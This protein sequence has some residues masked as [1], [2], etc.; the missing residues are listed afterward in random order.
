MKFLEI[1]IEWVSIIRDL[2][3]N[4]WAIIMAALIGFMGIYV[5]TRSIYTPEYTS[6]ATIVVNAKSSNTGSYSLFSV[7]VEM[8]DV[9]SRVLVE[10]TVKEKAS[11]ILKI[12]E[13]DGELTAS[14]YSET[15]FINLSVSSD[16]PQKSYELLTAVLKAYPQVS[17]SVFDNVVI[18]ILS[19]PE[20]P[21]SP[22][23]SVS[24]GNRVLVAGACAVLVAGLVVVFSVLRD[25]VKDEDDFNNKIDAKLLGTI[26]HERKHFSL[27]ERI[28]KKKKALLIHNNA[29]ISL[30]FVENYHKV[31]AKLEHINRHSGTKVFAITSVAENE[32]KSTIASNVAISLADRGHK[33]VLIDIDC[34]KPALY[35]I[36]NKKFNE[37][38]EFGY[39]MNGKIKSNEFRLK[40]YK[41]TSL[42]LA[43]NTS[44]YSEYGEW[45]KSGKISQMIEAFKEQV[46]FVIFDTAPLSVDGYVTDLAKLVEEMVIVVRTDV[47][48][49]SAINDAITTISEVGGRVAGCVLNDVYPEMSYFSLSGADERGFSYGLRYGKYGRYSRYGKY[50]KYSHYGR[51]GKYASPYMNDYYDGDD[52]DED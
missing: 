52:S 39:L 40:R 12:D 29:F 10:P 2:L 30:K 43:L 19:M 18:N 24:T 20:V 36:F 15:N 44:P 11:E 13:F 7:S 49:S 33:V 48:R 23:N 8:A 27:Q 5:A 17:D 9:I 32:G 14:V 25:T 34:K 31:A 28:Q 1:K 42:Y 3:K 37:K 47:V 6:T 35:K 16:S 22:S 4:A 51:Y 38:S 41:Q 46:D 21:H 50:G 26:P 45:I